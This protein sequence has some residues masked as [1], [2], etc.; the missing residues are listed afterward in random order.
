MRTLTARTSSNYYAIKVYFI[1]GSYP[2]YFNY[3]VIMGELQYSFTTS[4]NIA[5]FYTLEERKE[6]ELYL[7]KN[8]KKLDVKYFEFENV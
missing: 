8:L 4:I 5:L 2:A 3:Q 7:Y 6:A 1:Y